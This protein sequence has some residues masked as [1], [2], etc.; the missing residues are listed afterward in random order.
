M[1]FEYLKD[2]DSVYMTELK[3]SILD[4]S[5]ISDEEE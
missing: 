4:K 3:E 5:L 1:L 2:D